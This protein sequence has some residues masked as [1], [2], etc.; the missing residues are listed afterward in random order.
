MKMQFRLLE[1][2]ADT[3]YAGN[4]LCVASHTPA[5]LDTARMQTIAKEINFSET[6]FVTEH[7]P[8]GYTVRIFTPAGELPFAG[9]PT[10]GTAYTLVAQGL[11]PTSLIQ[12]CGAGDVPVRV[13]LEARTATMQ[14]LPPVFGT[15]AS[16]RA[17]VARAAGLEPGDLVEDLPI[18]PVGTG[19]SHVMVPVRD[20]E[21]LRRAKRAGAGVAAVCNATGNA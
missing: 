1:V 4:Q 20:E 18:Q 5:G 3:P 11:A 19:I 15:V 6:T 17:A 7:R 16:Y 12:R 2:C 9:H 21:A 13:D 8:D 10:L 14:Q